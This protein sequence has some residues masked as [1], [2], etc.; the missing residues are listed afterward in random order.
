MLATIAHML[1]RIPP[2]VICFFALVIANPVQAQLAG[3]NATGS[4]SGNV[5]DPQGAVI[6]YADI[7][8]TLDG[9]AR[10]PSTSSDASA[11]YAT[12]TIPPPT[13]TASSPTPPSTPTRSPSRHS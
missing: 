3:P 11:Q 6:P 7:Q 2:L 9:A 8:L 1:R 13:S 12:P 5:V 10:T 4:I